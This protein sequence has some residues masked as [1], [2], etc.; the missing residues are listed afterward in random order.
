MTDKFT[1]EEGD[2]VIEKSP[3]K[4]KQLIETLKAWPTHEELLRKGMITAT[5]KPVITKKP[6][7]G[8]GDVTS[9]LPDKLTV[10][11]RKRRARFLKLRDAQRKRRQALQNAQEERSRVPEAPH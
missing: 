5:N 6:V 8:R 10:L 9:A 7:A 4:L 3:S 2:I 1:W 11:Q